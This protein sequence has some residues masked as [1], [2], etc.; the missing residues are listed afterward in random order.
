MPVYCNSTE[1]ELCFLFTLYLFPYQLP[2]RSILSSVT[3]LIVS[4]DRGCHSWPLILVNN[5][6]RKRP[7]GM[8]SK[9]KCDKNL[10]CINSFQN[11]LKK[12]YKSIIDTLF[13]IVEMNLPCSL[14]IEQIQRIDLFTSTIWTWLRRRRFTRTW[15]RLVVTTFHQKLSNYWQT[16][17]PI[18]PS[19]TCSFFFNIL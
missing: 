14:S 9:F 6:P 12:N 18:C 13:L 17:A 1:M 4:L 5:S 8:C 19:M 10:S 11:S 3:N 7:Q 15:G 16:L 2:A